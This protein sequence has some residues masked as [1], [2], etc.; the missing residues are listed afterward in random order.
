MT[1]SD[2]W[3]ND[4][5]ILGPLANALYLLGRLESGGLSAKDVIGVSVMLDNAADSLE[6]V[7]FVATCRS[8][9]E[10]AQLVSDHVVQGRQPLHGRETIPSFITAARTTLMHELEA[11]VFLPIDPTKARYYL[12]P[13]R[14]W[15]DVIDRFP[16]SVSDIEEAGKCFALDRY[17]ASVFHSIQVV[18][19]GLL[20]LGKFMEIKD[21]L[22]GF[23]AVSNA[24]QRIKDKKY[25]DLTDFE[26]EHFAFFEQMNGSV[27]ALKDAWRNKI[28]HAQGKLT[29]LTADFS[30]AVAE[31]IYM[32]TRAF[33]R[34]L[35]TELPKERRWNPLRR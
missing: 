10:L 22:S 34:R 33:M 19:H 32:A 16:G 9:R 1:R 15:K 3:P 11:R 2:D 4:R 29:V 12:E 35:A 31:E 27:Q 18:E 7:G 17:A 6:A 20:A 14:D 13:R 26:K 23:T 24:L 30:P 8:F 5:I 25:T 21:P 28:N